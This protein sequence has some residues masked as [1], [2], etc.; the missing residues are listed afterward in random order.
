MI[1]TAGWS[2]SL[3]FV[4]AWWVTAVAFAGTA[5]VISDRFEI[6]GVEWVPVLFVALA[7]FLTVALAAE[8]SAARVG[9]RLARG[10]ASDPAVIATVFVA[11]AYTVA[12]AQS[13]VA[14]AGVGAGVT[15]CLV[16]V[17]VTAAVAAA[18]GMVKSVT[19]K[20]IERTGA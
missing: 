15:A 14:L 13:G 4:A 8:W 16:A 20:R 6:A 10:Q 19:S 2:R 17:T 12:V 11:G 9:L 1:L 7:G 18:T 5:D 3:T